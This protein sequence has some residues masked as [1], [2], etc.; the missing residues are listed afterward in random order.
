MVK[1]LPAK[2]D[3]WGFDSQVGKIPCRRLWLPTSVFFPG[4]SHGQSSLV[5]YSPWVCKESDIA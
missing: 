1:N 2:Q 4:E 5:N 3:M